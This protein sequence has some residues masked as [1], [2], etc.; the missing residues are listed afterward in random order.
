MVTRS[1]GYQR[2]AGKEQV[3][4]AILQ[5]FLLG[6]VG[7]P[8]KVITEPEDNYRHGDL[9]FPNGSTI[10]CKGQPIDPVKYPQNFVEV[11]E[12]TRND[13][14]LG[15]LEQ[16]A[17]SLGLSVPDLEDAEV[18]F[19]RSESRVG[20]LSRVSV[21]ITSI[22]FAT[23]TAYVNYLNGGQHLYVYKRDEILSHIR[24]A[25][26]SGFVRGSGNSNEDTYAVFIPLA[27]MR[28]AQVHGQWQPSGEEPEEKALS[29]LAGA[30]L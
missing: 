18:R 9:R 16:V 10:E 14:H 13:R 24:T 5:D 6:K 21:S 28:W 1:E 20:K 30:L 3:A 15:G 4:I 11:F 29:Q 8:G 12:A 7:N 25:I 22:S 17:A 23:A 19:Q 26:G 2:G 27:R